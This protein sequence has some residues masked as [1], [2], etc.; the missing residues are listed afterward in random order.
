MN[1]PKQVPY[2][3][4]EDVHNVDGEYTIIEKGVTKRCAMGWLKH[5]FLDFNEFGPLD[6]SNLRKADIILRKIG[7]VSRYDSIEEWNDDPKRTTEEI[8]QTLNKTM[9]ELG[10]NNHE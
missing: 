6:T 1:W 5:L 3:E 4:E 9:A 8:A 10:Y 7:H 2:F